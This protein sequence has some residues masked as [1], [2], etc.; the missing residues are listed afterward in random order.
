M[1]S[2]CTV[3]GPWKYRFEVEKP[4]VL[5]PAEARCPPPSPSPYCIHKVIRAQ[6]RPID[7]NT[8]FAENNLEKGI[9]LGIE[10]HLFGRMKSQLREIPKQNRRQ[11]RDFFGVASEQN[12]KLWRMLKNKWGKGRPHGVLGKKRRL[13]LVLT[14]RE[15]REDYSRWSLNRTG[16]VLPRR[17]NMNVS[18]WP[19]NR[20]VGWHRNAHW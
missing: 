1:L 10:T 16:L 17:K 14:G 8:R 3:V 13:E 11:N 7:A 18:L 9:L 5:L 20:T 19:P 2:R 15:N 12:K 4:I 6:S